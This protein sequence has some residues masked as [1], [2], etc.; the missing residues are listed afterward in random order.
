MMQII[1][2]S[3]TMNTQIKAMKT[4]ERQRQKA[5]EQYRKRVAAGLCIHCPNQAEKGHVRCEICKEITADYCAGRRDILK[6]KGLCAN[7]GKS[8]PVEGKV[9]C[10]GCVEKQR[11]NNKR[12]YDKRRTN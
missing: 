3:E 10:A 2:I 11:I 4:T 9:V 1:A 7:C 12:R 6:L 5:R 8:A